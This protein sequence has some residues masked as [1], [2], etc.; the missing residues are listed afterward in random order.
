MVPFACTIRFSAILPERSIAKINSRPC[1]RL[2]SLKRSVCAGTGIRS[3]DGNF[4]R[5]VEALE[6]EPGEDFEPGT[7]NPELIS[8]RRVA[9][10]AT[11]ADAFAGPT[12]LVYLPRL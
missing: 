9:S 5:N 10:R 8:A 11:T 6:G 7:W 1:F 2:K 4:G 3:C 12:D